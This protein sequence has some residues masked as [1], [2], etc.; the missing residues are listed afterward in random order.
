[1]ESLGTGGDKGVK[2]LFTFL[3]LKALFT[4]NC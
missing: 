4:F 3:L 2:A 1:M